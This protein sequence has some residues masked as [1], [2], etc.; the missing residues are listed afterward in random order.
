MKS[1]RIIAAVAG[2][3]LFIS[4]VLT[5]VWLLSPAKTAQSQEVTL[6]QAALLIDNKQVKEV[7]FKPSQVEI[8]DIDRNH[9][10]SNLSS[11]MV[12]ESLLTKVNEYNKKTPNAP[13]KYSFE[14]ASSDLSRIILVSNAVFIIMWAVTLAVIVY[15]VRTLSRNKS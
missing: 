2:F 10:Y 11:E 15:A 8:I 12:S 9:F 7:N 5:S 3:L 13:I 14:A 1:N 4:I 6:E